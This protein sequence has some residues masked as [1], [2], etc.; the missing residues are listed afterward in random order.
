MERHGSWV[1]SYRAKVLANLLEFERFVSL[2]IDTTIPYNYQ[3]EIRLKRCQ[4]G[5]ISMREA[6][7]H[8]RIVTYSCLA[9]K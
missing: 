3:A 7:A 9:E 8:I 2:L 4:V 6:R 5:Q 1:Q